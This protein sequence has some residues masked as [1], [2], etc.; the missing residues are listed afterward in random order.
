MKDAIKRTLAAQEQ[1]VQVPPPP[2]HYLR[3]ETI[4]LNELGVT[5][6]TAEL[7]KKLLFEVNTFLL[8]RSAYQFVLSGQDIRRIP[9]GSKS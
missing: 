7:A 2:T 5:A 3:C 1:Q 4:I 8:E 9:G 6:A